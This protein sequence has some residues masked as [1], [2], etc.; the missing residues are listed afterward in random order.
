VL[1]FAPPGRHRP[2]VHLSRQVNLLEEAGRATV[3]DFAGRFAGRVGGLV[4]HDKR[5]MGGR[6]GDLVA[7]L[8]S[9]GDR[10]GSR[11]Q[12]PRAVPG[13]R[14]RAEPDWFLEVAERLADVPSVGACV[15][16]GHLGIAQARA[17]FA[18]AHPGRLTNAERMN[19]WLLV[20]T[21]NAELARASLCA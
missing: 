3:E 21:E 16:V 18:R 8:R 2:V 6:T 13:V 15:D 14:G 17:G 1:G 11:P 12:G 20:L 4:V 10:L 5:E 9:L 7:G 19:H